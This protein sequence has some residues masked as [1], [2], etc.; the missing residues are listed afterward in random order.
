MA[1]IGSSAYRPRVVAD[2]GG[3]GGGGVRIG[4][5][6]AGA[7]DVVGAADAGAAA[8]RS[9]VFHTG[10]VKQASGSA[11]VAQGRTKVV[12]SVHGPRAIK[13]AADFGQKGTLTCSVRLAPFRSP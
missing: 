11:E 1:S 8:D 13:R 5:T 6:D 3:V 9:M 2:G 12:C 7:A 4:P 10:A